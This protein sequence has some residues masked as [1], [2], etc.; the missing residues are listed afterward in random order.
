VDAFDGGMFGVSA[1][2]SAFLDPQQRM[3]LEAAQARL[4]CCSAQ[5]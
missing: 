1:A 2:E 3:L 4:C 5:C